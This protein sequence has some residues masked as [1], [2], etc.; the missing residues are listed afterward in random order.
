MIGHPAHALHPQPPTPQLSAAPQLPP[1]RAGHPG[2]TKPAG[3]R[4]WPGRLLVLLAAFVCAACGLVYELE[5]VALGSHLLG[6]SVTQTSVVLS[7]MV[8]AMGVGSLLAKR[9]ICHPAAF[10]ALAECALALVGGLSVLG[11]YGCW[12]LF[13]RHGLATAAL[14]GTTGLIGVLI[15]V[16]IPLLMTL[17]QR[18]RRE[19]AGRA[20]ADLFA[21][22]Y[23]GAL[24]GGL[25]FPFLL[26]PALGPASGALLTGAVNAVAGTGVVLWL[27]RSEPPHRLR[28]LLWTG[29]ALALAALAVAA[30]FAGAIERAARGMLYGAPVRYAVQ[31]RYQ[32]IVLTGSGTPG[33]PLQLFLDGHRALCGLDEYRAQEALVYPALAGPHGRVLVFGGDGLALREVLRHSL[34]RSVQVVEPDPALSALARRDPRLAS[35]NGHAFEDPRVRLINADPLDWL[36]RA[37]AARYDVII[38]DLPQGGGA[39]GAEYHSEEFYG[40][41]GRHLVSFGRIAVRTGPVGRPLWQAEAGLRAAGLYT[42]PY[43]APEGAPGC[44]RGGGVRSSYLL[45]AAAAPPQLDLAGDAPAPRSLTVGL[46][47]SSAARLAARRPAEPVAPLTLLG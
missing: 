28:P 15:G 36:R 40:L 44:P 31:S 14:V 9:L 26:L 41:A 32:E 25:A 34:V 19:D 8:F 46:L 11:L 38:S 2:A 13:S 45:A 29:C 6:D 5:L 33:Q 12:A 3:D 21:A 18:I 20:A 4:P 1:E 10:F 27:F 22:D 30:V 43:R 42:V 35:L 37:D 7:V 47:R 23:V 39:H 17:M 24:L 16:E